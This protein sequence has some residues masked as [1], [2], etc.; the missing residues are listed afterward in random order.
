MAKKSKQIS[1]DVFDYDRKKLC[2]L[3]TSG[4]QAKG[5]ANNIIYQNQINGFKS[6]TMNLPYMLD[7]KKNFRWDFIKNEYLVRMKI[8]NF[9]DWFII[10]TPK[11]SKGSK[12]IGNTLVCDH[13]STNLK[14]KNLYLVFD[15]ENGIGT[16]P[17][18][19]NQILKGT[20]WR[21]GKTDTF[22]ERD[23]KTEK[24]RTLKSDGKAGAYQ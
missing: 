9:T 18:L 11:K 12:G 5:Q 21:L 14:T 22:Y 4:T 7:K 2:N 8:G 24:V 3:F 6:L 10:H 23:G 17:Y 20:G 19:M 15:D 13:L 1:L 16:L